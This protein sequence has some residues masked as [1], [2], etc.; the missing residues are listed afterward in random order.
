MGEVLA[1][2][3]DDLGHAGDLGCCCSSSARVVAGH[4][5]VHVAAALRGRYHS[6]EGRT[7]NGRV[8]VG[9]YSYM[10]APE[11]ARLSIHDG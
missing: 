4:Q 9:Q 11:F 5:H 10:D 1:F 3:V 2:H 8:V 7:L 6:F